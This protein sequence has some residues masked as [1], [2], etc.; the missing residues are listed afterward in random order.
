[1]D[2]PDLADPT[3]T[4]GNADM[5]QDHDKTPKRV[6]VRSGM[7]T[8]NYWRSRLFRNSY[9]DRTGQTVE[10]P[11]FYVRM[12]FAGIT[13]R[14]RL[15]HADQEKAAEE[16]L[17][18]FERLNEGGW[19]AITDRSAKMPASPTIAQFCELYREGTTSMQRVPRPVSVANYLRSLRQIC[20]LAGVTNLRGL[21]KDAM[22]KARDRYRAQGRAAKRSDQ[23]IQNSIA[24]I[25][26]NAAACFSVESRAILKRKGLDLQNPFEG[27]K[28]AQDISPVT[29]MERETVT[30]LWAELPLLRDGDPEAVDPKAKRYAKNYRKQHGKA[31]RWLPHDYRKPHPDAY[32]AVLLAI[33]AG[34]RA[35]EIDKARWNWIKF[36]QAGDCFL[37]IRPEGDFKPKG[38]TMRMI[39]IPQELHQALIEARADLASPFITGGGESRKEGGAA[40]SYRRSE[41]LKCA[42]AWLR[43]RGVEENE[44]RGNPLHRL[45]KQ[46][47]SEVATSF[48]LF[49]AQK[50]LGHSSPSVTAKYYAAATQ[51]PALTH[52]R[53]T[54]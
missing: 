37:E 29:S 13:R 31:A 33:G 45:R 19:T 24:S 14:V 50:L 21:T 53:I 17:G 51:L 42:N 1:M 8:L 48:G 49:A 52:V 46:F 20:A 47:G 16:A 6:R 40:Q 4:E 15:N 2:I 43:A 36:D 9:R 10:I 38:G 41:T 22:E 12:R 30:R 25:M 3:A 32:C 18:L 11:E 54:G 28:H 5:R 26:R 27:F 34:L 39:K 7:G 35:N 23:G 44:S